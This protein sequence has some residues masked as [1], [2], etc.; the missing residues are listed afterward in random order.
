MS[1]NGKKVAKE[2]T[3]KATHTTLVSGNEGRS[4]T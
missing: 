1:R 2:Q 3:I 4:D